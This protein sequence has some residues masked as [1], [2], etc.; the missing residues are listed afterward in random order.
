MNLFKIHCEVVLVLFNYA[1]C[2]PSV[3]QIRIQDQ[4][5][6]KNKKPLNVGEVLEKVISMPF[7]YKFQ[8]TW[9][10]KKELGSPLIET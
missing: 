1:F 3:S 9:E 10:K 6:F 2:Y 5:I 7:A 8:R 4:K